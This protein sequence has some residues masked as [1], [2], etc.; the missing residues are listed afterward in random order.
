MP[1]SMMVSSLRLLFVLLLSCALCLN[2]QVV[3]NNFFNLNGS[4]PVDGSVY[5]ITDPISTTTHPGPLIAVLSAGFSVEM[6]ITPYAAVSSNLLYNCP[7][8]SYYNFD[9]YYN[10]TI[11]PINLFLDDFSMNFRGQYLSTNGSAPYT[12]LT[13]SFSLLQNV[14]Y[15]IS[16]SFGPTYTPPNATFADFWLY[17]FEN[18]DTCTPGLTIPGK[19]NCVPI[20]GTLTPVFP[21]YNIRS[22]SSGNPAI[23][24]FQILNLT[25]SVVINLQGLYPNDTIED[26]VLDIAY[27]ALPTSESSQY[28]LATISTN[29]VVTPNS[30]QSFTLLNPL[31]GITPKS[32]LFKKMTATSLSLISPLPAVL[33]QLPLPEA[34]DP[35]TTLF[36]EMML[37]LWTLPLLGH[38]MPSL[39]CQTSNL[40]FSSLS[41]STE[42]ITELSLF[43]SETTISLRPTHSTMELETLH[44]HQQNLCQLLQ[45]SGHRNRLFH[46]RDRHPWTICHCLARSPV[47]REL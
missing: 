21:T 46:C 3:L 38:T 25:T 16:L 47:P 24:A 13:T 45:P 10:L 8:N 11:P 1:T 17:L 15:F 6:C 23:V 39:K 20:T 36:L 2:A 32:S 40:V 19:T 43:S 4:L 37:I 41:P 12:N 28:H 9:Y 5:V 26:L 35:R 31:I 7:K 22:L 27:N 30:N 14:D 33:S 18:N 29:Y 42:L 44:P 34:V